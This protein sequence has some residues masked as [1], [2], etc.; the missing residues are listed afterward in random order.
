MEFV[1]V[2]V[3]QRIY[4]SPNQVILIIAKVNRVTISRF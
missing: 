4:G 1:Y 3:D 2:K